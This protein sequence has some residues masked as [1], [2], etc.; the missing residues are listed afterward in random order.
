M[1]HHQ[2]LQLANRIH[3]ALM[4]E[5]GQGIDLKQMLHSALYARDVLLV[6]QAYPGSELQLLGRQFA[7]ATAQAERLATQP[8]SSRWQR[9]SSGFGLSK[10]ARSQSFSDFD[11]FLDS[12]H[13]VRHVQRR[14]LAPS[15][16]FAR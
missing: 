16:W 8:P 9:D 11:S 15:T 5:L 14:W 12:G 2:R 7:Q 3:L 6:C 4:R 13:D 1:D 10:P